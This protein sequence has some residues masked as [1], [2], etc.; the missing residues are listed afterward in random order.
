MEC[1]IT[2]VR[3]ISS[4]YIFEFAATSG[5]SSK[6]MWALGD[7][8]ASSIVAQT[9][10]IP[11][12]PWSGSGDAPPP[13]SSQS[14]RILLVLFSCCCVL[15]RC[16][17]EVGLGRGGQDT[18]QH[19]QCSFRDLHQRLCAGCGRGFGGKLIRKI[20]AMVEKLHFCV[21]QT[22][23]AV[24][25]VSGQGAEEIGYPVVIKASEGGGGK[26]IRKVE[27]S[28]DFPGFFRQVSLITMF[29]FFQNQSN[30]VWVLLAFA[31]IYLWKQMEIVKNHRT[32]CALPVS[33]LHLP[34]SV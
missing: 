2:V 13:P 26:G 25:G 23:C 3:Y 31:L 30:A 16:R 32:K 10:G 28:E 14:P 33:Q 5:P 22:V 12:L 7:K 18:G 34:S 4:Y 29:R 11:T 24:C 15:R 6:A 27:S 20:V 8:V 21:C 9:A 1:N 17:S 19:N